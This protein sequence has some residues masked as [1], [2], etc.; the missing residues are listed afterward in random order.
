MTSSCYRAWLIA[1]LCSSCLSPLAV[2]SN[3]LFSVNCTA[4]STGRISEVTELRCILQSQSKNLTIENILWKKVGSHSNLLSSTP[5]FQLK[6]EWNNIDRDVSLLVKDTQ[7]TDEGI[8][9]CVVSSDGGNGDAQITLKVKADYSKPTV[10]LTPEQTLQE[11]EEVILRCSS[12][13]GYPEAQIHWF[14]HNG[15]DLSGRAQFSFTQAPNKRF[16]LTS[17]LTITLNSSSLPHRCSVINQQGEAETNRELNFTLGPKALAD[18]NRPRRS[19]LWIP[20]VLFLVF[21][22]GFVLRKIY[23]NQKASNVNDMI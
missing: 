2:A 21:F 11:G 22:I 14:D 12:G 20:C 19:V 7:I 3:N 10:H 4:E 1:G 18:E 16:T 6:K 17:E 23:K 5:R 8:Y 9:K 13:E 15:C